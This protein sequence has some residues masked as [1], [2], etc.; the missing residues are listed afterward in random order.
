MRRLRYLIGIGLAAIATAIAV[1]S[2]FAAGAGGVSGP[3]FYIDGVLYRT[4]AT[5]TDLSSTGAPDWTYDVIYDLGQ[6]ALHPNV[7]TA[8]PGD[9][10]FNGGRW[11][12]HAIAFN[13]SYDVT[14][15]AHDLNGSGNLDSDEEIKAALADSGASGAV[16]LGIVK[17]FVC[18]VVKFPANE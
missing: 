16:D 7:A 3:A 5:P 12:V 8:A 11:Q 14:A 6:G 18:T 10:G 13:T 15:T 4:V 2:A 1:T 9:P 17:T